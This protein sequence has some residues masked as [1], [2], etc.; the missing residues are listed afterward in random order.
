MDYLHRYRHLTTPIQVCLVGS[1]GFGRS[2][3]A[4]FRQHRLINVRVA[5]DRSAQ[6]AAALWQSLGVPA[7]HIAL[8]QCAGEAQAAWRAGHYLAADD[9]SA[10]LDLPL[11]ALVEATGHP[12]AGARHAQLAIAAGWH[13]ALASK[14]VDSV[15]GPELCQLAQAQGRVVTPVDGDQPA[16]LIG[17]ITWAQALGLEGVAAGKASEYDFVFDPV[18]QSLH[19]NGT[20]IAVPGLAAH[21]LLPVDDTVP[22]R[23]VQHGIVQHY[24]LACRHVPACAHA[25][26]SVLSQIY[27]NCKL[28]PTTRVWWSIRRGCTRRLPVL[29]R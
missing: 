16:L 27:A 6:I 20:E 21:W 13:V 29:V 9:L 15:V 2:F 22:H 18:T 25:C 19:S 10:V 28:L 4:Q 5:V 23:T 8:C 12:E 14:E 26:R 24:R 3:I 1:G 7:S 11:H 17:L